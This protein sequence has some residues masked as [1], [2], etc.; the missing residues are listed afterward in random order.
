MRAN[1][2]EQQAILTLIT[3]IYEEIRVVELE[4]HIYVSAKDVRARIEYFHDAVRAFVTG[5]ARAMEP[6]GRLSLEFLA[7]DIA[8]I[9]HIAADPL[10]GIT[11]TP[12]PNPA[13]YSRLRHDLADMYKSYGVIFAALLTETAD[14]NYQDK[15]TDLNAQVE[16]LAYIQQIIEQLALGKLP[17]SQV[18]EEVEALGDAELTE[19]VK[20]MIQEKTTRERMMQASIHRVKMM[21]QSC[22][23]LI[24]QLETTHMSYLASQ[25][26]VYEE[27]KSTVKKLAAQ[28]LNVAGKFVE[29]SVQQAQRGVGRER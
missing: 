3:R 25:L 14:R 4:H 23:T 12:R 19:K 27:A 16:H 22:D 15:L 6:G 5:D 9:R 20:R 28:G 26:Y 2:Q 21:M 7:Y 18:M 13:T 11:I 17:I 24:A 29:S 8:S 1:P 10:Q